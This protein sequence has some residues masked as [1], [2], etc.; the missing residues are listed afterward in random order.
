[1]RLLLT[2]QLLKIDESKTAYLAVVSKSNKGEKYEL[3]CSASYVKTAIVVISLI[4][5][6]F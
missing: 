4:V 3:D 1:M 2:V 5:L 6:L